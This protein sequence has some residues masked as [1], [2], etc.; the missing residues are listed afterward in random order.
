MIGSGNPVLV[1]IAMTVGVAAV[2]YPYAVAGATLT[3]LFPVRVRYS[4]VAV[5]SNA[6]GLVSGCVPL[7]ATAVLTVTGDHL[8]P[9]ALILGLIGSIAMVVGSWDHAG[10]SPS[11]GCGTD[12]RLRPKPGSAVNRSA[13]P[14]AHAPR[15]RNSMR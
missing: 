4:G 3:S 14:A 8:W 2:S 13:A 15:R 1:V 6:A 7:I 11:R 5:S 10:A 9:N 12:P